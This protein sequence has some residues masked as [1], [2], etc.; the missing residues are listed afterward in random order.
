MVIFRSGYTIW[1]IPHVVPWVHITYYQLSYHPLNQIH[2]TLSQVL[3]Y[4]G[5]HVGCH[6]FATKIRTCAHFWWDFELKFRACANS[7]HK[8]CDNQPAN[9]CNRV[10][11][12]REMCIEINL[13][14]SLHW[15]ENFS[16]ELI[17]CQ[18]IGS[19]CLLYMKRQDSRF[20]G[21]LAY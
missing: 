5:L 11:C 10:N 12:L 21:L 14:F 4:R 9:L 8:I 7:R 20:Y 2:T 18:K 16:V 13:W 17:R 1:Q 19:L 3:D 15:M 6:K